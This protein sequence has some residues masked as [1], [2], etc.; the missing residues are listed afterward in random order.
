[1]PSHDFDLL[2]QF[3]LDVYG[4][5]GVAAECIDAQN[6]HCVDVCVLLT[7]VYAAAQGFVPTQ[8]ALVSWDDA[9]KDWRQTVVRQIRAVRNALKALDADSD[10][11]VLRKAVLATELQAER[12]EIQQLAAAYATTALP[13]QSDLEP[14]DR[15]LQT[16][17]HVAVL[18]ECETLVM[19]RL[20]QAV[21]LFAR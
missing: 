17:A 9:V 2:W 21:T 12:L 20:A 16:L 5:E 11:S 13:K 8:E 4:V 15:V 7:A 14:R 19:P 1:M 10:V 18:Y 6:S 3:A